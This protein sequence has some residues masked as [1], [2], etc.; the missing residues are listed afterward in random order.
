MSNPEGK[1]P[2]EIA[3]FKFPDIPGLAEPGPEVVQPKYFEGQAYSTSWWGQPDAYSED[4]S[5][6]LDHIDNEGKPAPWLVADEKGNYFLTK[7]GVKE[8][9]R[10]GTEKKLGSQIDR[11]QTAQIARESR[12]RERPMFKTSYATGGAAKPEPKLSA[13][14]RLDAVFSKMEAIDRKKDNKP[15]PTKEMGLLFAD[16]FASLGFTLERG[17]VTVRGTS[18]LGEPLYRLE[19]VWYKGKFKGKPKK[20]NRNFEGSRDSI[21]EEIGELK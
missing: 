8:L 10:S 4:F 20:M 9:E 21:L 18:P 6:A 15:E 17:D 19:A 3:D 13:E 14:E 2:P 1:V 16:A 5:A 7:A 12:I 11:S